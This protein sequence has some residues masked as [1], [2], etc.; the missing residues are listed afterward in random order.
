MSKKESAG[1]QTD[2]RK[3]WKQIERKRKYTGKQKRDDQHEQ[4]DRQR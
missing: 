2:W 1:V 4:T 3:T